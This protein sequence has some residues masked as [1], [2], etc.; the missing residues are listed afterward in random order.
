MRD[1]PAL[2]NAAAKAADMGRNLQ[3]SSLGVDQL[4]VALE[5]Y[6]E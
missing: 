3:S 5:E 2:L 1:L 4:L 6:D